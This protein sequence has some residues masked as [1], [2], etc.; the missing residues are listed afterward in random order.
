M[1]NKIIEEL[2]KL[3]KIAKSNGDI[4]VSAIIVKD[5]KIIA[6]EYNK[7]VKN[8]NPL[9]H[10]EILAIQKAAKKLKIYNLNDCILYCSLYPCNMC[11]EVIKE[12][13][14]KKVFYIIENNKY[15]NNNTKYIQI[16]SSDE[17]KNNYIKNI[18]D[19]F[20]KIR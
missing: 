6:K 20:K 9:A 18:Q 7:K 19:F 8:N 2:M 14:I 15:I 16:N 1:D 5:N 3:C 11:K 13:R 10:A 17:I 12:A 4:P